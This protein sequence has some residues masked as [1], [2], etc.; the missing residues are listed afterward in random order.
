MLLTRA[1]RLA[2]WHLE[3]ET[4]EIV[5]R[6]WVKREIVARSGRS[7]AAVLLD[8]TLNEDADLGVLRAL[9]TRLLHGDSISLMTVNS[10]IKLPVTD[11]ETLIA[12]LLVAPLGTLPLI[13]DSELHHAVRGLDLYAGIHEEL[14]G[15][16]WQEN[17]KL[18][19]TAALSIFN[20]TGDENLIAIEY[21]AKGLWRSFR[22]A[23][24][25][26]AALILERGEE[27]LGDIIA[28]MKDR[29]T[30]DANLIASILDSDAQALASGE[31]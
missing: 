4:E 27:R 15:E 19:V 17:S 22:V 25:E 31:L 11:R 16:G 13:A 9:R 3:R 29:S 12:T 23:S 30:V 8:V 10:M 14:N 28:I 24:D 7:L 5:L 20:E 26:A 18:L 21:D 6:E 2:E 1:L